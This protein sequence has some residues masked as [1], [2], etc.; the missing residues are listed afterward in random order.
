MLCYALGVWCFYCQTMLE[1]Y[2]KLFLNSGNIERGSY[3]WNMIQS[4]LFAMQSAILLMVISRTGGLE[5]AGVFSI[6]YA[7]ASLIYYIGEYG[8][9]KYQ[10]TDVQERASFGDY[11]TQRLATCLIALAFGILY[12]GRG[13]IS[14][15]Y[16][17]YKYLIIM[18]VCAI[19]VLEAYCDVFFSRYQQK[20]RLDVAAKASAYRISIPLI[21]CMGALI[22]TSNLLV[23][24][25]VWLVTT[26]FAMMTSFVLLASEFGGLELKFRRDKFIM[27]SKD[28]LPLFAGSFLLLYVG[29]APKYA[30]DA[31]MDDKAQACFNFIF[32]PVFVIGMLANF[33]FNPILVRLAGE[34]DRGDYA[35]F[36]RT[37]SRQMMIIGG[38]TLLAVAVALTIGCPVLGLL[39]GADLSDSKISLTLLML[40]GG[41]LAMANFFIVVVTVVRGQKYLIPAYI[42]SALCAK[43]LSAYFVKT[44]GVQGASAL[45]TL[46][47]SLSAI[48]FGGVLVYS[49]AKSRGAKSL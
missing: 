44:Y 6:A 24:M 37:V 26:V 39:F 34:W 31:F 2:K 11:H 20:G 5:D 18:I 47:M 15:Q 19:K 9:R 41:M 36:K 12:A 8:V 27:I 29:N 30:I 40:G 43:L 45:Y 21:C 7:I 4:I 42:I 38:I 28:C 35:S 1:G 14:G 23:S 48:V 10:V 13:Y 46:L 16:T 25:L 3:V 17:G 22:I 32:M 49:A 33:I